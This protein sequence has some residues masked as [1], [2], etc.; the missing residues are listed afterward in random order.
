M[1]VFDRVS[2]FAPLVTALCLFAGPAA[3]AEPE[4]LEA[5]LLEVKGDSVKLN[6][7]GSQGVTVGQ[8]FDLYQE[9]RVFL[10]PLTSGDKPLVKSHRRVA[11]VQV[12]QVEPTTAEARVISREEGEDGHALELDP[13]GVK[14]L[15]NPAAVAPN[16]RPAFIQAPSFG[17]VAWGETIP[18]ELR[19]SNESDDAVIYTWSV[20]GGELA[21]ERTLAPSN[22]WT[23]PPAA[24][25][26]QLTVA[27]LDSAGNVSRSAYRL[28][29]T[30]LAGRA[31]RS[32]PSNY[33][34]GR[35]Y[36]ATSRY[37]HVS[38]LAFD[39]VG[40]RYFLEPKRGW[41]GEPFLRVELPSGKIVRIPTEGR[42]F[43]A[44]A[45][46]DPGA[47][48]GAL[49]AL[50]GDTK[51]VLH[52]RFG[53]VG[54]NQVLKRA[55][56]VLGM[57]GG[58]SGN[59]RFEDPVDIVASP[60]GEIYVLDAAQRAVQVFTIQSLPGQQEQGVF[61]VSFGRPGEEALQLK[62][63]R[64]LAVGRDGS[65]Y[66]LDDGR[67]AVVV[68]RGWRPVTEFA[69]GGPEEELAGIAVDPFSG[70]IHVLVSSA[71][72][73]K[74]FDRTGTLIGKAGEAPGPGRL[75]Q[76]VRVRMDATRVL[77]VLDRGGESVVRFD[78]EGRLLGR[79]GGV[80]LSGPLLIAG[81]PQG[82]FAALERDEQRVTCFDREGWITA[83]FGSE[84][85]KPGQFE[86]PI[87][88]AVSATGDVFVL[89]AERKSI[90]MFSPSGAF[91]KQ[92]GQPGSGPRDLMGAMDLST[93]NDR[94]YLAVVQQR[95][96][97]NFNLF[98]PGRGESE[99]TWGEFTGE[100]T[101]RYGCVS[102]VTGSL[103]SPGR[104]E[105]AKPWYW[106]VDEDREKVFRSQ[107]GE[108][109]VQVSVAFDQISDIECGIQ[110]LVFVVDR[111]EGQVVVLDGQGALVTKL[112]SDAY[113]DPVDVGTD[114]YGR[115]YIYDQSRRQVVQLV[116]RD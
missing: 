8:I 51:T 1:S 93:V 65:V 113:E 40:R 37:G 67:K 59:A 39:A 94:S 111:G 35:I 76:P 75:H 70:D 77:W 2:P 17:A 105:S 33:A 95:P 19:V 83:R 21:H 108:S 52:Y 106:I 112:K 74:R 58:G 30:G 14:A 20:S 25:E 34:V 114:D 86:D 115:V 32:V 6:K 18:I 103:G 12:V 47:L 31:G 87:D 68:Y 43:T 16:R 61:L 110:D 79:T 55:P 38:D 57:E 60:S 13:G 26:Y 96:E 45:V 109:P 78:H 5:R 89:D 81:A 80:E 64:G 97:D 98:H 102:G 50:D 10:L 104:Q 71:G 116:P 3:R 53:G 28:A 54:W 99:R 46:A 101:P 91:L 73:V 63:P 90:Q 49:L 84:G 15:H 107:P 48:P 42:T 92:L 7:G 88:V 4:P 69:V 56:L 82:G 9:A 27:A 29:S 100:L 85:T 23:A 44:V 11:R 22:V 72:I 24:G 62:E 66:V 36:G 41:T